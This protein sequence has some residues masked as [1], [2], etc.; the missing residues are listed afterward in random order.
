MQPELLTTEGEKTVRL[1]FVNISPV[2]TAM[3]FSHKDGLLSAECQ[4]GT[5]HC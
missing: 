1:Q 2:V 3:T 4:R 5:E